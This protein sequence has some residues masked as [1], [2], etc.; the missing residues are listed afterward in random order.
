MPFIAVNVSCALTKAQ[1]DDIKTGLGTLIALLPGKNEAGLMV[2]ISE[3]H[4][5]YFAGEEN[6]NAAFVDLRLYQDVPFA[7]K[8]A[9]FEKLCALLGEAAD[10]Q[11]ANIYFNVLPLPHW[12]SKGI[13][14]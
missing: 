9:F 10:I 5:L 1:K 12:G 3:N 14:K 11:A 13:F 4:T 2:D 6:Q 7:A 8:A